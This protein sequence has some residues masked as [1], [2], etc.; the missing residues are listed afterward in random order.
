MSK[1]YYWLKLQQNFFESREIKV[2][3]GM[4]SGSEYIL[5]WLQLLLSSLEYSDDTNKVGQLIF[6]ESIP[7]SVDLMMSVFGFSKEITTGAL[8]VYKKLGMVTITDSGEMWANDMQKLI[9]S[10]TT[11]AKR[12][13]DYRARL[14][15]EDIVPK[16][17]QNSPIEIEKET[18]L[19]IKLKKEGKEL[20]EYLNDKANRKF[21]IVHIYT[22]NALKTYS[23]ENLKK[24]VDIKVKEWSNDSKM[25]KCLRQETLFRA[26]HL[27]TYLTEAEEDESSED[28]SKW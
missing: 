9:G 13:R 24:I 17:S 28:I 5:F 2:L 18:E 27:D 19:D 15:K 22:I 3:K 4:E 21:K 16:L 1:R 7:W 10:E 6:K 11:E 8:A 14:P 12:K 23:I 20:L 26:S 25:K